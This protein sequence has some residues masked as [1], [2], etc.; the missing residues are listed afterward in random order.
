M[1]KDSKSN[2]GTMTN[3]NVAESLLP[4]FVSIFTAFSFFTVFKSKNLFLFIYKHLLKNNIRNLKWPS[5]LK[6]KRKKKM[7]SEVLVFCKMAVLH[8]Y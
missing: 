3:N 6:T 4:T 7:R 1:S 8:N 2:H 5:K